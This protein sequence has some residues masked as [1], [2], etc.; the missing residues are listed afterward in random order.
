MIYRNVRPRVSHPSATAAV[1]GAAVA[2]AACARA[3]PVLGLVTTGT[4]RRESNWTLR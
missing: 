2:A 3:A 4:I 1:A